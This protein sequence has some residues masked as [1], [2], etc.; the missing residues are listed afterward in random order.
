[1]LKKETEKK[2][3]VVIKTY[4]FIGADGTENPIF[5]KYVYTTPDYNNRVVIHYKGDDS[6]LD[7]TTLHVRT[8]P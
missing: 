5:K 4:N 1:M 3:P 6:I 2:D 7:E 8:F